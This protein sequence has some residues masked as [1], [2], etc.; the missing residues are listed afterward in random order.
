VP[1][2]TISYV[3]GAPDTLALPESK[4]FKLAQSALAMQIVPSA[5]FSQAG[6]PQSTSVSSPSFTP[7]EQETQKPPTHRELLPQSDA[8]WHVLP[9]GHALPTTLQLAPPQSRSV[10]PG[11]CTP[12]LHFSA[13]VCRRQIPAS[14]IFPSA[15][16][17]S[18]KH[19]DASSQQKARV[20]VPSHCGAALASKLDGGRG[21][22]V[23]E[24]VVDTAVKL[25]GHAGC[26]LHT[27]KKQ[28][29][30]PASSQT[31]PSQNGQSMTSAGWGDSARLHKPDTQTDG[32]QSLALLQA[33]PSSHLLHSGPPQSTSDSGPSCTVLLQLTQT[34]SKQFRLL[35][36]PS[37]PQ[38][39]P[40][41]HKNG[42][43][44]SVSVPV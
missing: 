41:L 9:S 23:L 20:V 4:Q 37:L 40:S 39:S 12:L 34:P 19:S 43:L 18:L 29:P 25:F 35:Q 14:Q 36:S 15:Q 26:E 16:L 8:T 2:L 42:A 30:H 3:A 1:L 6:P 27:V 28:F 5:H 17:L 22:V 7:F 44:E 24:L 31:T 13:S 38:C 32:E 10:S 11:S 33:S 21:P